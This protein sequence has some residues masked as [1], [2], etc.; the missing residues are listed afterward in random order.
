M[1]HSLKHYEGE[2]LIDHRNSRGI[3]PE[4]AAQAR[5]DGVD[6]ISVGAGQVFERATFLCCHCGA[7]VVKS[8]TRTRPRGFCAKCDHQVCDNPICN[9]ECHPLVKA[10]EVIQNHIGR[11]G[12]LPPADVIHRLMP[13]LRGE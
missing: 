8:K 3:T 2:I 4:F 11:T 6:I 9:A 13:T 12:S 7:R 5:R 10:M 1:I